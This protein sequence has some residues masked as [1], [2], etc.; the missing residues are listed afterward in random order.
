MWYELSQ[1]MA[2]IL[3][4]ALGTLTSPGFLLPWA[5]IYYANKSSSKLVRH[6][7]GITLGLVV[8]IIILK[9]LL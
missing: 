3:G 4:G 9:I 6:S 8:H 1:L 2:Q 7:L 5:G